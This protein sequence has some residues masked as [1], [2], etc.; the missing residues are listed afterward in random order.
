MNDSFKSYS[1]R[2]F[3]ELNRTV[4][5][6]FSDLE[7]KEIDKN[8]TNL[9]KIDDCFNEIEGKLDSVVNKMVALHL[10]KEIIEE[11]NYIN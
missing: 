9:V 8:I 3:E 10:N 6:K 5:N 2:V 1:L 7:S 4:L 11:L